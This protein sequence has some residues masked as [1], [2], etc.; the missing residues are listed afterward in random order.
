MSAFTSV[1]VLKEMF[2]EVDGLTMKVML[3][4]DTLIS[5][6]EDSCA[7]WQT[8]PQPIILALFIDVQALYDF[9][10]FL[11]TLL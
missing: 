4:L 3:L 8:R 11:F 6:T 2:D 9:F 1:F 7:I 10:G 5:G